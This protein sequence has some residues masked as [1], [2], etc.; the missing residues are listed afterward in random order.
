MQVKRKKVKIK[1]YTSFN[2]YVVC[3]KKAKNKYGFVNDKLNIYSVV[4]LKW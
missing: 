3:E 2:K 1:E 4:R